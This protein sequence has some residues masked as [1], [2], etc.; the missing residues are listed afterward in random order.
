MS[1]KTTI[2]VR[3]RVAV[4]PTGAY[5]AYGSDSSAKS[6]ESSHDDMLDAHPPG[7]SY[8]WV[9]A[10]IPMPPAEVAGQVESGDE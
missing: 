9:T 8:V 2:K 10:E 4:W 6:V 3:V 1:E 5:C 7:E